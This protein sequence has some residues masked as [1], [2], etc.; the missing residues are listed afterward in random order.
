MSPR[1]AAR[2]A[3]DRFRLVRYFSWA[4]G[5]AIV[6]VAIGLTLFYGSRAEQALL[7]QG[8]Q[9]NAAQLRLLLNHLADV[10][11]V[12]LL[13]LLGRRDAPPRDD[14]SVRRMLELSA[15][16]VAGTSIVKLNLYNLQGLTVFST[17]LKQI[18]EDKATY[19]G[20]IVARGGGAASQLSQRETFASIG[21]PL[22]QVDVIGSSLPVRDDGGRVVGVAEIYDNV[23]PLAAAI[24]ATRWHVMGLS[25]LLLSGLYLALLAIVGH[26]DRI[27]R[28]R[29]RAVEIEIDKRAKISEELRRSVQ[30]TETAQRDRTRVRG[31][32]RRAPRRRGCDQREG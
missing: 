14:A 16:S 11:R 32:A 4:S 21:G 2:S 7:Q 27:L 22:R 1:Q 23:T 8:E 9:K 15:R 30:A 12:T 13:A 10:D 24:R 19:P 25:A 17:E 3:S 31:R 6:A 26:A 20:F 18:G 28:E 29:A 5:L